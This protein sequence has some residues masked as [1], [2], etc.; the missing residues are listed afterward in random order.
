MAVE[1]TLAIIKPDGTARNIIGEVISRFERAGLRLVALKMVN[2]DMDLLKKHYPDSMAR[3]VGEKSAKAGEEEA[4]RDPQAYGMK[5]LGW[6]REFMASGPVV[7]MVLEGENAIAAARE[8]AGY[9]D[10]SAAKPGTIRRD[11]STDS[12]LAANKEKRPVRNVV[13]LSGN[14]E[15]AKAE[16]AIWFKPSEFVKR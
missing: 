2:A 4:K 10:P 15:E 14:P 8:I 11:F 1:R 12:I 3:S 6:L 16:I 5:V 7:P 13:H 9:T